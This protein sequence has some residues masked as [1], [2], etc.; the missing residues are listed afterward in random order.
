LQ[1]HAE[2]G[3]GQFEV[4]LTHDEPMAA[5]DSLLFAKEAII[6]VARK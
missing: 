5:A 1:L 6:A 4:V 2:A 3:P